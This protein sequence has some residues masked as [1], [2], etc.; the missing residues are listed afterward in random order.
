M[1]IMEFYKKYNLNKYEFGP[2]AGVG[3]KTLAK[4][5]KGLEI[6]EDSKARILKA[7]KVAEEYNLVRPQYDYGKALHRG[8]SYKNEFHR[9]VCEYTERF[10]Q[11]IK[12]GA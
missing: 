10:K 5:A 7:V 8:L 3:S 6:R 9:S 11:L 4:F 2:I 12:E 1:D